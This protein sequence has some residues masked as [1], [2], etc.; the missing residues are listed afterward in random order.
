METLGNH[1]YINHHLPIIWGWFRITTHRDFTVGAPAEC[2][3]QQVMEQKPPRLA[4]L[5]SQSSQVLG[6]AS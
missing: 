2:H 3:P 4:P 5:S 1:V 6:K